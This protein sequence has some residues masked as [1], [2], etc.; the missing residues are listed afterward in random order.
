MT[1]F[2]L[3]RGS[4]GR[5]TAACVLIV[6]GVSVAIT[7]VGDVEA[8]TPANQQ[9]EFPSSET[10]ARSVAENTTAGIDIGAPV[11]ATDAELDALTYS[12][13]GVDADSFDFVTSSGQLLTKAD[14]DYEAQSAYSL[15]VSVSDSKDADGNSD[16]VIDDTI[17]VT[18]TVINSDEPGEVRVLPTG[19]QVRFVLRA[20]LSDPDGGVRS[21]TWRWASSPNGT[22]WTSISGATKWHFKPDTT[23]RREQLRVTAR[24]RDAQGRDK[25]AQAVLA[26][27]VAAREQA[28]GVS[29]HT[30]VSGLTIPWGIDFT[31]DKTMLVTERSGRLTARLTDG[32]VNSVTADF[33]DLYSSN[34]VGL[35]AIVVD[36]D[37]DTNRRF[38]TCQGHASDGD[39]TAQVIAWTLNADYTEATRVSDPLVG[40]IPAAS[41]HS[42]C[43][44]RFGPQGNLWIATGDAAVGTTPQ[45]LS[46]LGGKILRVDAST[47]SGVTGNP[48]TAAPLVYSYGHRN[49]QGLALRPGTNEMWVVEH[50]PTF[51]DE[52][53]LL[54]SGGNYGWDPV[55]GYDES[56]PMTDLVKYPDAVEAKWSS[57][58]GTLAVSGGVFI[59]GEEWGAWEGRLAVASLKDRTLRLFDFAVDG[60]LLSEVVVTRLNSENAR[61]RTPMM[62]PDGALYIS[63]SNGGGTDKILKV[64]PPK[65]P[66]F[67]NESAT[68]E[69]AE[70]AAIGTI[71]ATIDATDPNDHTLTYS[72]SGIDADLFAVTDTASGGQVTLEASLDYETRPSLQVQLT[73]TDP[74]DMSDSITLIVEVTDVDEPPNISFA[75]AS[76]VTALNNMLAV[77]E[78]H[79]GSLATFSAND[80]ENKAGL[81]YTWS[82]EGSDSG[83]F[84]LTDDGVLSFVA[85]P[86][87]ER[88]ADSGGNNVYDINVSVRDSD[89]Y[90]ANIAV[91]VTVD[92]V[93]EPPVITGDAAAGIEEE[94]TLIIGTYWASDPEGALVAWQPLAGD[95][96]DLFEFSASNGRLAFKAARDYENA[97]DSGRNNTY[98]VTLRV[99]AGGATTDFDVAVSVTNKDENGV[100]TFSS[101]RPRADTDYTAT[102]S[103]PDGV[104]S[105][106]W[107]WERS[108]GPN[109]PWTGVTGTIDGVTTSVYTPAADDVGDYLRASAVYI[110]GHGPNKSRVRASD[111]AVT[112]APIVNTAPSFSDRNPTRRVAENAGASATV[113]AAVT[114]TDTDSGDVVTYELS[115]SDL[116]TIDSNNGRISVVAAG[117][118]DHETAPSHTVTVTASDTLNASDSVTVTIEVTDVNEPPD[119]VADTARVSEDGDV[120]IDILANDSDQE[121]E[122]SALTPRVITNPR[123]GRA[124]VN[125][126]SNPGEHPTIT[127]M[128]NANYNGADIF[129]YEVRDSGSPFLTSRATVSVEV[130]AMNDPPTFPSSTTTRSVSE[131]A[132][133]G[134]NVGAPVTAT[135]VD[136][137]DTLMYSLFGTDASSFDIG[138][139]SGQIT[140]GDGVVFDIATKDTYTVM[141]AAADSSGGRAT[142]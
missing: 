55:P 77:D 54:V 105:T 24:Y 89:N 5:L 127:Y 71:I 97:R 63:T 62:G 96:K 66:E 136:D 51:D 104:S 13:A 27:T 25:T 98:D 37:F 91:T 50:G 121:D 56:V 115:G 86:D 82:V 133:P 88:P 8:Q 125:L 49:V 41:R 61:L 94:G 3:G 138:P 70:N 140:V 35:M 26:G 10:G 108:A 16:T 141:V 14:L 137:S 9:P 47:G 18:V 44:L 53:N 110:D 78:N 102:L 74:Q 23:T 59:E 126:P 45:D 28:P 124:T 4:S 42:G 2:S 92:R 103:D 32:T 69:V 7:A 29:V 15:T 131:N 101:P 34:E 142:V 114:A 120:T 113:G 111:N 132:S 81:T 17:N 64:V 93:N 107:T 6:A 39:V 60:T 80:P 20:R 52:I 48:F 90:T 83:D 58:E 79:S 30:L 87:Y 43:R 73:A 19:P 123:R 117:L 57:G 12:M 134:D 122:R 119:A 84:N 38:Y 95:D 135:D 99:S 128:P 1:L 75:A 68:A 76:A 130:D 112:T 33:S 109:G 106:T 72:L 100:L 21:V 139:D 85:S 65:P 40:G 129:T 67:D 11:A 116:F 118:L 46:S 31:P 22:D 36:P